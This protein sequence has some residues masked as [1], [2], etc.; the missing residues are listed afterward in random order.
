MLSDPY[1]KSDLLD[2]SVLH[3]IKSNAQCRA[4]STVCPHAFEER[5]LARAEDMGKA[6]E[7]TKH[8]HV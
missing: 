3:Y 5:V 4:A 8:Y 1:Y 7:R 6:W 2:V